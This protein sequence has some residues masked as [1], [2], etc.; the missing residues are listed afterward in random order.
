MGPDIDLLAGIVDSTDDLMWSVDADEFLITWCN[1][2]FCEYFSR[3]RGIDVNPGL[4]LEDLLPTPELVEL[5][6]G[7]YR[8]TIRNGS[9]ATE[10]ESVTGALLLDLRFTALSSNGRVHG[11]SV[12]GRDVTEQRRAERE[13]A[14]REAELAEAQRIAHVGSFTLDAVTGAVTWS[15][16]MFR[17]LGLEPADE[18][19]PRAERLERYSPETRQHLVDA[20][21]RALATG[22]PYEVDV[23]VV[24]TDGVIR[25][26][27]ARGEVVRGPDGAIT[28][29]RGTMFDVTELRQ[30]QDRLAQAQGAELIGRIAGGIAHDFNNV[31]SVIIGS[32]ELLSMELPDDDARRDDVDSIIEASER[33]AALA[34]QLLSLG[35]REPIKPEVLDLDVVV[36]HLRPMLRS[37]LPAGVELVV[38]DCDTRCTVRVDRS[39]LEQAVVNL[40]INARDAMPS[41]GRVTLR[42]E[43]V[44]IAPGDPVLHPPAAPGDYVCLTVDDTG[45]GMDPETLAHIF[46]PFFTTKAAARGSGLGLTSVEGFATQ[47]GGFVTALSRAGEGSTFSI[48]LPHATRLAHGTRRS[49]ATG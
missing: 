10:Y 43:S 11:V 48:R 8:E 31:L 2:A 26:G 41:G 9:A 13:L 44:T 22:E 35:R 29:L 24:R 25:S 45:V 27:V 47:S 15:A 21:G 1:R 5:F 23:D 7:L 28:G 4:R 16:E 33:A 37:L 20:A 49:G 19:L 3:V 18:A 17:I 6:R 40:V 14:H 12:F 42:V 32:A 36:N 34:R 38:E 46:D 39:R 30:A